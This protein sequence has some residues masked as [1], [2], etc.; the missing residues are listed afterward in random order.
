MSLAELLLILLVALI[1]IKPARLPEIAKNIGRGV[2]WL[3]HAS[4]KLKKEL[5]NI[6]HHLS[7][8]ITNKNEK[9]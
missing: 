3:H 5:G 2:K 7:D 8:Q 9:S 1:V 6:S 4:T